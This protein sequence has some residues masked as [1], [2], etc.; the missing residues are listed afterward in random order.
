MKSRN[1]INL[2]LFACVMVAS[3]VQVHSLE[4]VDT[5]FLSGLLHP[6]SGICHLLAMVAIGIWAGQLGG[7]A[8]WML[9]V[10]F[11]AI[12]I[13]AA[14]LVTLDG[15][16]LT[17]ES[18][19]ASSILVL[20]LV[21]ANKVRLSTLTVLSIVGLF[22]FCHGYAHG[23]EMPTS[24]SPIWFETGLVMATLLLNFLGIIIGQSRRFEYYE[25]LQRVVGISL[26]TASAFF[27][28]A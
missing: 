2:I 18:A 16:V 13:L 24:L 22:A 28:I 9:P 23:L 17:V 8:V 12:M 27:M 14:R 15:I 4:V 10:T 11:T 25:L 26:M 20:G 6:F 5:G 19:L 7:R 21:V 1:L 3:M